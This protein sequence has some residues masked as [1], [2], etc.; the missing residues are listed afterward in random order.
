MDPSLPQGGG[1]GKPDAAPSRPLDRP[2][3][4]EAGAGLITCALALASERL[5]M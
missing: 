1:A 2:W 4:E 5:H 3:P